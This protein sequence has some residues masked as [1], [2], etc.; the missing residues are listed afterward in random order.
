MAQVPLGK[1]KPGESGRVASVGG[2]ASIRRRLREMG[3]VAGKPVKV[4]RVAPLGDP[5]DVE[6]MG[7]HLSLRRAEAAHV[8]VEPVSPLRAEHEVALSEAE[9]GHE[10]RVVEMDGGR[11]MRE[12][13]EQAG[14]HEGAHLRLVG[15]AGEKGRVTLDVDGSEIALGSRMAHRV[16]VAE[17]QNGVSPIRV[18]LAGNPNSGKTT[19]FNN[20]TGARQHVGNYPGVTI[21]KKVG[22]ASFGGRSIEVT[23]LPGNYS[24][25]PYTPEERVAR[26]LLID[27]AVDVVVAVVDA[28]N[29][30]R[31]LYLATQLMELGL[32]LVLA[33]NM[34]DLA[35][36]RGQ[37]IDHARL[38]MLLG[39]PVVPLVGNRNQ[40]TRELFET[41]LKVADGQLESRPRLVGYGADINSELAKIERYL[42]EHADLRGAYPARWV[43]LKLLE[44]DEEVRE[45]V[46]RRHGADGGLDALVAASARHLQALYGDEPEG[47]IADA[48]YGFISGACQESV[49]RSPERRHDMS[50]QIDA[51]VTSRWLGLPIF[52]LLMLAMFALVFTL[53]NIGIG[54]VE[55]GVD[56]LR[57]GIHVWLPEGLIR[58]LLADGIIAGVGNIVVFLPLVVLLFLAIAFLEDTGYMARAAFVI[59]RVMHLIG[60]HGRSFIPMVLG[61]GCSVP[62]VMATRTLSSRQDRL[63]TM[64][65][66]PLISCSARLPIYALL[67]GAFFKPSAQAWVVFSLYMLGIV[68]A[69]LVAKLFRSTL[70]RGPS[71]PFVMELPPYR[72]PT[73]RGVL[74]HMW[75]RAWMYLKRA[76]TVILLFSVVMWFLQA[77]PLDRPLS[78]DYDAEIASARESGAP[79]GD[80][81]ALEHARQAEWGRG[82]YAGRVGGAIAPAL[83]PI[84]L[85]DWKISTALVSGFFAKETVVSTLAEAYAVG[86]N[87]GGQMPLR[88]KIQADPFYS[89]LKAYALM[90][91]TLLYVPCMVTVVMI[92]RESGSWKW[93]VFSAA[94]STG[95]AYVAALVVYQGGRLLGLG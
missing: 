67:A 68:L 29:L 84:G 13:L 17:W 82:S 25:T 4:V 85:G 24:L 36:S 20:L 63:T 2:E 21:E 27:G 78:R 93:A 53:G 77:F 55:Q 61:L 52:A 59:D 90:V 37:Q 18:A 47:L 51:I 62:A 49:V 35:R 74:I 66:V 7:Y 8:S 60:L 83:R 79:A 73:A 80:V 31:N 94:Y 1:M 72:M 44:G 23:D 54:A 69:A 15:K 75:R 38:S 46:R 39:V 56:A 45:L 3:V 42:D 33:F 92:G 11:G 32:P 28:S 48:R 6:V 30:E 41:I 43:A 57:G 34:S 70:F 81:R 26:R 89:P 16:R 87:G 71:V 76:A 9:I 14:V 5:I 86:E 19:V 65:V 40:G 12:H 50:D 95:L 22:E 10:Y 58:S 88:A 64:L 91:F